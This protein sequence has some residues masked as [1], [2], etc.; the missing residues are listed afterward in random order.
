LQRFERRRLHVTI[1]PVQQSGDGVVASALASRVFKD[2]R[3]FEGAFA[4]ADKFGQA[5]A[6]IGKQDVAHI[7]LRTDRALDV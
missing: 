2:R 3:H 5:G 4:F 1:L 6:R 7:G